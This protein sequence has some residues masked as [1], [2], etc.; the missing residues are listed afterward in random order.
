MTLSNRPGALADAASALGEAGINLRG[1]MATAPGGFPAL[2]F[3]TD[4]AAK[5]KAWLDESR[6][7]WR[8]GEV[9]TVPGINKPGEVGR[10]A[11]ALAAAGVNVEAAY[12]VLGAESEVLIAFAVDDVKRAQKALG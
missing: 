8:I 11:K 9:V 10:L 12:P 5:A 2:R 7:H 6:M 3:V 4:D 1:F